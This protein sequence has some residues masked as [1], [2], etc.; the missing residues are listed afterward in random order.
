MITKCDVLNDTINNIL[1][2]F[3]DN[4][5]IINDIEQFCQTAYLLDTG[6]GFIMVVCENIFQII[7]SSSN[8]SR[9]SFILNTTTIQYYLLLKFFQVSEFSNIFAS[10]KQWKT[11]VW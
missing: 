3:I 7:F 11:S 8:V 9:E 4:N 10:E 2:V 5:H 1:I 6:L